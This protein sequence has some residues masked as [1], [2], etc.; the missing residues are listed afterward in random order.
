M[1]VE[2]CFVFA[3]SLVFFPDCEA[4]SLYSLVEIATPKKEPAA[5]TF[6]LFQ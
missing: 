1:T 2:I 6:C 5:M 4:I 3:N